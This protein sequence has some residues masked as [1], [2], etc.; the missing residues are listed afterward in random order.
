VAAASSTEGRDDEHD[1]D[2]STPAREHALATGLLVAAESHLA[3]AD[4]ALARLAA[5][6][7]G[8]CRRCG[9]AIG[10]E[11]LEARPTALSCV[12]CATSPPGPVRRV[13]RPGPEVSRG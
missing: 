7:Y 6:A 12:R 4:L 8:R 1:P 3:E 11:R 5:G 9:A 2:G 13:A 10:A